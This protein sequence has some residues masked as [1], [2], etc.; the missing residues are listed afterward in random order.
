MDIIFDMETQDPDDMFALCFLS[1]HP[2]VVLRG[3]TV[4]PGSQAQIGVIRYLLKHLEQSHV[5]IGSR[6]PDIEK[7]SVSEFHYNLFGA[8]PPTQPDAIAHEL[9]ADRFKAYPDTVLITGAPLQNLGLLLAYHPSVTIRRW[10]GQG[11][12]A[13]DNVVPSENRLPKFDGRI[14]C[15]T[16]NFN[17]ATKAAQ[18]MLTSE[19]VLS[20]DIVSKNVCHGIIYDRTFHNQMLPFREKTPGLRMMVAGMELYLKKHPTGKIFHDPLAACIA[21]NR[22]IASFRE[23]ELYREKGE[24][25]SRLV[26]GTNTFITVAVDKEL[27]SQTLKDFMK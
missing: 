18:A 5:P 19:R 7:T 21:V 3:V 20:R 22:D 16:F 17:G 24:W 25:G 15:P 6:N 13:G 1:S 26:E 4:T 12:F 9:L 8:I 14:T 23:V 2:A 11:G 10:V 27:F